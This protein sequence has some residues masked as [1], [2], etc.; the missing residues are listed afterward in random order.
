[1]SENNR[2]VKVSDNEFILKIASENAKEEII[3]HEKAKVHLKFG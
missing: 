1:M 2:L 3:E